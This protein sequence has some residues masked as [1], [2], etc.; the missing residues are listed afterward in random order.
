MTRNNAL[1]LQVNHLTADAFSQQPASWKNSVLGAL[2]F[3]AEVTESHIADASVPCKRIAMRRLD[4][5][6]SACEVWHGSAPVTQ[7]RHGP[8]Y[9]SHDGNV[10]FGV[11]ACPE[12][13]FKFVAGKTPLQQATEWAYRQVFALL[14]TLNYPCLFRFWNYLPDINAHSH[15]LERY[16]QF[17]LGRQDAFV[18]H[19]RALAGDVPAACALGAAEGPLTIAFLAGRVQPTRIENPRQVSAYHYP[20]QYGPS[21]PMFSRASLVRWQQEE[22]LLLSGTASVVGSETL[23]PGDVLAQTHETLSNIRAILTEANRLA[24]R[25]GFNLASLKCRVYI[26][27]PADFATIRAALTR[28]IGNPPD[29]VYLQAEVCRHDLMLE[30]EAT[31]VQALAEPTGSLD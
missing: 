29:A 25:P 12:E 27:N 28:D 13:D 11:I 1:P 23:H 26:R 19:D 22:V 4:A 3:T 17:N 7:G 31:A 10:L 8:I 6:K 20:S 14:E 5:G 18:A 9:Y 2:C 21:S 15:G 24:S 30:I 16:R